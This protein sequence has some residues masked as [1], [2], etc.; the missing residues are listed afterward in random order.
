MHHYLKPTI[1]I[2]AVYF[3]SILAIYIGSSDYYNIL[4]WSNWIYVA[5]SLHIFRWSTINVGIVVFILLTSHWISKR[6]KRAFDQ[7]LNVIGM[8]TPWIVYL[9]MIPH[10]INSSADWNVMSWGLIIA[11]WGGLYFLRDWFWE[12]GQARTDFDS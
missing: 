3:A 5:T 4:D 9:L 2:A 6:N 7:N 1:Q 11:V 8:V 12:T 10:E